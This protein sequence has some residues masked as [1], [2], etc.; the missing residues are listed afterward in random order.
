[1]KFYH[2]FLKFTS[3]FHKSD[4][5]PYFQEVNDTS[6]QQIAEIFGLKYYRSVSYS[7]SAIK[8]KIDKK[9]FVL[10]KC[11]IENILYFKQEA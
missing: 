8:T 10:E 6:L 11:Q 3:Y 2:L 1:M 4:Q 7:I 9:A 5:E